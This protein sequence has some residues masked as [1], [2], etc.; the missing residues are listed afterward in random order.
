VVVRMPNRAPSITEWTF[1]SL[2][3]PGAS[4]TGASGITNGGTIVGTY[5]LGGMAFPEWRDYTALDYLVL[6]FRGLWH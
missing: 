1:T 3:Y 5:L 4:E 2:D 6:G